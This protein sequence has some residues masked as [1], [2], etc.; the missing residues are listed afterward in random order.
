MPS[1]PVARKVTAIQF[2][3]A[4]SAEI[5]AAC[6]AFYANDPNFTASATNVSGSG[7]DLNRA[8]AGVIYSTEHVSLNDSYVL[9]YGSAMEAVWSPTMFAQRYIPYPDVMALL[10]PSLPAAIASTR[11][12]DLAVVRS[13]VTGTGAVGFQ[14]NATRAAEVNYKVSTSTTATIGGASTATVVLEVA[15]TNSATPGDWKEVGRLSNSQT[16]TLAVALQSVQVLG[17]NI[18]GY[19]PA[20]Y[21]A[22]LRSTVTGTGSTSYITGQETLL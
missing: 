4:N 19:V 20:G 1:V 15:P 7:F 14:V 16:I 17:G 8:V 22:K 2:T 11:T 10:A 3:G 21:Y 13:I 6:G 12:T 9:D 5:V 18:T